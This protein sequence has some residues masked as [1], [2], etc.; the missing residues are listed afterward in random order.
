MVKTSIYSLAAVLIISAP[1]GAHAQWWGGDNDRDRDPFRNNGSR[2]Q[3]RIEVQQQAAQPWVVTRT[4]WT[5]QDEQNYSNFIH[6]LGSAE[7]YTV[8]DCLRSPKNPYRNTDPEGVKFFSDCADFPYVLRSYFAWKNSLPFGYVTGI[9][10][11]DT[12]DPLIVAEAAK[13]VPPK[14]LDE[15]YA[16]HGI[17]PTSRRALVPKRDGE[18]LDYLKEMKTLNDIVSSAMF[19]TNPGANLATQ[20]DFYSPEIKQ[21]S[22]RPGTNIYDPNG[23]VAVVYEVTPDG[24]LLYFDA[25]PDNSITHG[26]Y[27][28]KFSRSNPE[29]GAGLKNFRPLK[30]VNATKGFWGSEYTGGTLVY[31]NN[32]QIADY[33]LT[34]YYGAQPNFDDW[35]KGTFNIEGRSFDYQE[36]VQ[37]MMASVKLNITTD[38]ERSL[39]ELCEDMQERTASV[40]AAVDAGTYLK[41]HIP[42]LPANLFQAEGEWEMYSTPGRDARLRT[43]FLELKKQLVKSVADVKSGTSRYIEYRGDN[44]KRDLLRVYH[45]V[46]SE[47]SVSYTNSNGAKLTLSFELAMKRLPRMSFDP[48]HCPERRWGA[49]NPQELA[50][51][52]EDADKANWYNAE[53]RLRNYTNRD[54][55]APAPMTIQDL[56]KPNSS[57]GTANP[58]DIDIRTFLDALP[59]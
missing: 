53:Q 11:L 56:T 12:E 10:N 21:G 16:T 9:K 36:Y 2:P 1:F 28:G 26:V 46:N 33:S 35:H 6:A 14:K 51:C 52:Q 47:C 7:C 40:Q 44:L 58:P 45:K 29:Q 37:I 25:H 30:L 49:V 55:Q 22:I 32:N 27:S 42:A 15:R 39:K 17:S 8:D 23:H 43:T 4:E 34:Q 31:A 50:T 48:Y 38:F 41:P 54:W 20:S 18:G 19:R 24:R 13:A 59:N 3:P 5:A 57:L